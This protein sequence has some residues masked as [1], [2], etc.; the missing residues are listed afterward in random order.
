M[1]ESIDLIVVATGK[2]EQLSDEFFPPSGARRRDLLLFGITVKSLLSRLLKP[3]R[4]LI[5]ARRPPCTIFALQIMELY[6]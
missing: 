3:T 5:G 6:R 1:G 4:Y 2:R